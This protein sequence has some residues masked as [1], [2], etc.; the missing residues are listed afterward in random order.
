MPL[1][2]RTSVTDTISFS[3]TKQDRIVKDG[4]VAVLH[5][6]DFGTGWYTWH[7]I[8]K[9]IFDPEVVEMVLA[10]NQLPPDE[11]GYAIDKIQDYCVKTYNLDTVLY[12]G[13]GD[14]VISWIPQGELFR[15][16]EYDGRESIELYGQVQ[17][18]QA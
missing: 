8:S 16:T 15:I 12:Q 6:I 2:D 11:R 7:R 10:M 5:T 17:W 14:L 4:M 13:A 3:V 9:L 1:T 18:I